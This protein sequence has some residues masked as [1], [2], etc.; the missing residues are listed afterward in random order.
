MSKIKLCLLLY[1]VHLPNDALS[2]VYEMGVKRFHSHTEYV[3]MYDRLGVIKY[4]PTS[5]CPDS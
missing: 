4:I 2:S 1:V 3:I 5:T